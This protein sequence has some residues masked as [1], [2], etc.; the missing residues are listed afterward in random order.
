MAFSSEKKARTLMGNLVA[1]IHSFNA[2]SV[3]SG[4]IS[5]GISNIL[6]VS[7]QNNVTDGDGLAV[8]SGQT[9]ALSG[10]TSNDTGTILVIGY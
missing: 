2:A 8:P 10:L 4:N 9:V 7:L 6:H 1:E 5:V 3:T